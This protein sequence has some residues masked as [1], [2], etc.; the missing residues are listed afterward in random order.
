M[1]LSLSLSLSPLFA[2]D[3]E[4]KV[5]GALIS[6]AGLRGAGLEGE[7]ASRWKRRKMHRHA[8]RG[9]DLANDP[10]GMPRLFIIT[11]TTPCLK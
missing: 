6:R 4:G 3:D 2:G 5:Y 11:R 9:E 7:G 8:H 10:I 1:S